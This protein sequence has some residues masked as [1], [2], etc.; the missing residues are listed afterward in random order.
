[1]ISPWTV[2]PDEEVFKEWELVEG[3]A[4]NCGLSGSIMFS[5]YCD[6][7]RDVS[8]SQATT[9]PELYKDYFDFIRTN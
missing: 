8:K 7:V 3:F 9:I 2:H 4:K 6:A 1:M 5:A